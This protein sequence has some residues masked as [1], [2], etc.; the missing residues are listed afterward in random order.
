MIPTKSEELLQGVLDAP[1]AS[2]IRFDHEL[3]RFLPQSHW[4]M[5]RNFKVALEREITKYL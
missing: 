3:K 2:H 5:I 1:Q 4:P